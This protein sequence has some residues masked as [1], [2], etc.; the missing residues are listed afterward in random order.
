MR[1][2]HAIFPAAV[3]GCLLVTPAAFAAAD[4]EDQVVDLSS[5]DSA[6]KTATSAGGGSLVR[7]IVGLAIVLAV[8]YGLY[9]VLKQVKASKESTAS[10][11]G[12]ET[13]ATLPLGPG[14][15]LHL[16][17]AGTEIVLV[18]TAE[19]GV[20]PIRRY[21]EAEARALGLLDTPAP[22]GAT[23]ASLQAQAP[24]GLLDTLRSKTVVSK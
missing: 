12:L 6:A 1:S 15:A 2:L 20:T 16:V 19:H 9:W 10:G 7:T 23:L 17:R 21:S 18:G 3:A 14:R 24:R 11:A 8:I 22:P 4:P 5:G 13:L